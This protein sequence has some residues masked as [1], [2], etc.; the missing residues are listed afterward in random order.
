MI[1]VVI[2]FVDA[3]RFD[4]LLRYIENIPFVRIEAEMAELADGTVDVMKDKIKSS[5]KRP[6]KGSHQLENAID[7][8]ELLNDPGK[9]LIIGIGEISKLQKDAPYY[10]IL[11]RGGKVKEHRV[12]T[13]AFAPGEAKPNPANFREGNWYPGAGKYSFIAGKASIEG[14]DYVG[15]AYRFIEKKLDE[16]II[17]FG[18]TVLG[19]MNK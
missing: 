6:D 1:N 3:K 16:F 7:W 12:P 13:G 9:Q 17:S 10:E 14:I 8:K 5:R 15:E 19:G 11:D 2:D 4:N 18:G